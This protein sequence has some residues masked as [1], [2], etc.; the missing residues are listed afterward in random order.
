MDTHAATDALRVARLEYTQSDLPRESLR[1][2]P[3]E[4]FAQWFEQALR[5]G[6]CQ[7]DAMSLCT[8][9]AAGQPSIRT[10]L[11]K[12][13]DAR[14]FVF[15]T[16]LQSRKSREIGENPQVAL[17]FPWLTLERQ[18]IIT[19]VAERL[20]TVEAIR[21]FLT[22]PRGSRLAAWASRQSGVIAS[23]RALEMEWERMAQK[24]ARGEVPLPTFWGGY[25]VRAR[26]IEFWQGRVNRL[27][28][29]Y[30]YT[31]REDGSWIIEQLAP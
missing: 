5:A 30:L 22:R 12:S 31:R 15:Y 25:R 10:V 28:D 23:R 9:S 1:D 3:I 16:N 20:S 24:F 7:P 19:G 14:G 18:V 8:V 13:F 11:M 29:R 2:D 26:Q 17:M 27:H 6:V 21:Y 4:Q